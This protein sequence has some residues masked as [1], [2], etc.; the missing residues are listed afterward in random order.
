MTHHPRGPDYERRVRQSFADQ[1]FMRLL[2]AELTRVEPGRA[3]ITLPYR[4]DLTQ[5]HAFFHGGVVGTLADNAAGFAGFSLMAPGE[6]PLSVE[7]KVNLMAPA[8]GERLVARAEV[9][10]D[11][12]RLKVCRAE[13]YAVRDGEERHCATALATVMALEGFAL[14][15][16]T[17]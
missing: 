7:F 11:G 14:G 15:E 12:R 1:P 10:R 16:S 2:G 17:E 5:Q 8:W 13:I 3:E 4:D 6:Q 9:V